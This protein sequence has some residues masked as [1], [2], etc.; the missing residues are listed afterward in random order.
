MEKATINYFCMNHK[1]YTRQ[2]YWVPIISLLMFMLSSCEVDEYDLKDM[3]TD[4]LMIE[5]ALDAPIG[6]VDL[7]LKDIFRNKGALG[8]IVTLDSVYEL[9]KIISEKDIPLPLEA[10]SGTDI[11]SSDTVKGVDFANYF[12]KGE[13]LDSL[14]D[15]KLK[16]NV[17]SDF[18]FDVDFELIFLRDDTVGFDYNVNLPFVE[19]KE[20]KSLKRSF[21][22]KSALVDKHTHKVLE[23]NYSDLK[24]EF[25]SK[26]S[27]LLQKVNHIKINYHLAMP[28]DGMMYL[29]EDYRLKVSL[30]AYI[31]ARLLL[32]D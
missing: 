15:V 2:I 6:S 30:S 26:D 19:I 14:E 17:V 8:N 3:S 23:A 28:D 25:S 27:E 21:S 24:F 7:T 22:V 20:I 13:V 11:S 16:M 10:I 9:S 4:S 18:P 5:T 32:N 29:D 12:G 31:K 1:L